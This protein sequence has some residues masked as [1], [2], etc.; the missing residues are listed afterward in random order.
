MYIYTQ[1]QPHEYNN[2]IMCYKSHLMET[3]FKIHISMR[4]AVSKHVISLID[5][6]LW[7]HIAS[8]YI[9]C[10]TLSMLRDTSFDLNET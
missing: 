2:F 7:A 9:I 6:Q 3:R 5:H 1:K 4:V 8:F 10:S